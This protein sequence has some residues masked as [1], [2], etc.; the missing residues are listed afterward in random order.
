MK[1]SIYS[2]FLL[3]AAATCCLSCNDEWKEEQFVQMAS[4]KSNP[5]AQ[6]VTWCYVRY[7]AQG[8]VRFNLPII[9]SGS[10]PN[11]KNRTIHIGLDPDTL[12]KLNQEQYGHR[13]ELYFRQL[14]TNY[15]TMPATTVVPEGVSTVTVPID[16]KLGDLDQADKWVLPLQILSDASYDY[17]ANPNKHYRRT[18]LRITPFNDYSGEYGG[19][20]YKIFLEGDTEP[21]TL[22]THRTFVVDDKT[23][24]LYAGIRDIDYLDRKKY[25]VFIRFTNDNIDIQKKKLEIWSD[26]P[27]NKLKLG[28]TQSYYTKDEAWDPKLP[29]LKH[30]Y[31]TLYLSYEFEDYTTIP[32]QRLKYK[33]EGTLS[34]QRD[35]NTLIPDEDQQIQW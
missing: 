29:Y 15:Y 12:A 8:N 21:L 34:M 20:L 16:F 7:N 5:T 6:G 18:M 4:F 11:N 24:F 2:L 31:T 10:T 27:D 26:N 23:I 14:G 35:L 1:R 32:G 25:K 3:I 33:V 13:Q 22:N 17:Q 30:V 28:S 19:T 9:M